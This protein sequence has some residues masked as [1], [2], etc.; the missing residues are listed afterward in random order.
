MRRQSLA[1]AAA[2][3]LEAIELEAAVPG[4]RWQLSWLIYLIATPK[5]RIFTNTNSVGFT[6]TGLI[7][8]LSTPILGIPALCSAEVFEES[9]E[10]ATQQ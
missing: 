1:T 4:Q 8:P 10:T 7:I 2:S 3:C 9:E 6:H 5:H